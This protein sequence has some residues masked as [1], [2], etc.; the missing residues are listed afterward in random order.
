MTDGGGSTICDLLDIDYPIFLGGMAHVAKAELAAAVSNAGGLGIVASGGMSP[1]ELDD[2]LSLLNQ[3]TDQ[4]FGVNLM[5]MNSDIQEK[6]KVLEKYPVKAVTTGA[7]NPSKYIDSLHDQDI[8]VFPVVPASALAQR[9][10]RYGA[11]GIVAEGTEAGGHVGEVTTMVLVPAVVD[12]VDIPVVA[13]GGI[14]DGR[15]MAAALAL[16]A[17]GVQVGTRFAASLESPL[18]K[19]FMQAILSAGDR[20]TTVTGRSIGA[21]VRAL[22]NQMTKEFREMEQGEYSREE[23]EKLAS[24]GLQRAVEEGD[25]EQGSLM[26][27]QVAALIEEQLSVAE[28]VDELI[29]DSRSILNNVGY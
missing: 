3:Q 28:I 16:G 5:L 12:K 6:I 29:T 27:G 18:H 24:G 13:A 15:S 21:P 22:T 14:G 17:D 2:E 9:V 19:G 4:S 25:R 23:L 8:K 20:S 10:E 1:Q 11:D 26:A 7:G